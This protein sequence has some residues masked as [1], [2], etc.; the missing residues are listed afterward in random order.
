MRIVIVLAVIV[1]T[2]VAPRPPRAYADD[3]EVILLITGA[4]IAGYLAFVVAGTKLIYDHPFAPVPGGRTHPPVGILD[5]PVPRL[6]NR[7]PQST[8]TVTLLC[9]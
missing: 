7:C 6:V 5:G 2:A 1:S 4:A 8:T 9:W 3:T